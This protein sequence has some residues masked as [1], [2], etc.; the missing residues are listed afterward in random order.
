MNLQWTFLYLNTD[1]GLRISLNDGSATEGR[2]EIFHDGA[3]GAVCDDDFGMEEAKTAC[4]QLGYDTA[5][6]YITKIGEGVS[7]YFI[8]DLDCLSNH[9]RLHHCKHGGWMI[10]DCG[11]PEKNERT[12]VKCQG[13]SK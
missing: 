13:G 3:W 8:D 10:H 7:A 2:I 9:T 6:G 1:N 5:V 4:I 12:G 11:S